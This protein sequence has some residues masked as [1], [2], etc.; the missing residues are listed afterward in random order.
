MISNEKLRE[1]FKAMLQF[2]EDMKNQYDEYIEELSDEVVLQ[3]LKVIRDWEIR[4]I[5]LVKLLMEI[6][7]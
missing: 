7:Q 3:E 1:H 5:Q 4:H 6:V 2:E